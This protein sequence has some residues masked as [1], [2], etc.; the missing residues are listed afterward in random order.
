MD[1]GRTPVTAFLTAFA[2]AVPL[3]LSVI[4]AEAAFDLREFWIF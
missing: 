4:A 1:I 3:T 2:V